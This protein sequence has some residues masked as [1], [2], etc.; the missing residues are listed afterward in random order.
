MPTES[1]LPIASPSAGEVPESD[2]QPKGIN[3]LD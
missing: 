1:T 3:I 2:S